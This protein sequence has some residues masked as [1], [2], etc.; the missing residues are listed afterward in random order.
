MA[1]STKRRSTKK[2][3]RGS[4]TRRSAKGR[5][6]PGFWRWSVRLALS[7]LVVLAAYT[8]YLDFRITSEFEGKRWAIPARVYARPLELYNGLQLSADNLER[9]IEAL[10]YARQAGA[11]TPGSYDRRGDTFTLHSRAFEFW[12]GSEPARRIR[13]N[14]GGGEVSAL[15]QPGAA[16]DPALVRLDP[17]RIGSIYPAKRED[18]VLVQLGEVPPTLVA[19]LIAVEDHH[20]FD[21]YG[22][23]FTGIARALVANIRAGRVVQGGS[24]LTQQ[25]VKNFFLTQDRTLWRK[26]NEAVMAVLLELHYD[27]EEILE[28]YL[29]EVYLAQ[30][31]SRAIHGFGLASRFYFAKPLQQLDLAEQALLIGMVKGPSYYNPRSNPGRAKDRRDLV[32]SEMVETGVIDEDAAWRARSSGLG[33]VPRGRT[34]VTN[35]PAFMDLVK[36]HLRRDYRY[37][38]LSTEGLRIFTTFA[39]HVQQATERALSRHLE[40]WDE[41]IEGAAVM[42]NVDD[43]EVGAVVGGRDPRYDGFNRALDAHRPIGSLIKPAIYLTALS[44]PDTYGLGTVLED[45]PV[46]LE[47]RSGNRWSPR[48]YDDA[49]HG[50]VPLWE[51]LAKSYN[52]PA[53]RLGLDLGLPAVTETLVELGGEPPRRVYPSML[54]GALPQS[55]LQV[56]RIY[57]TIASGGFRVPLRAVRGVTTAEGEPLN[58]YEL[59]VERAFSPESVYLLTTAMQRVVS[60]GTAQGLARWIPDHVQA[61]GKTGTTDDTRDSWFAGF[62][63]NRLGV[64]WVGRDKNGRTGLTGSSGAMQIWGEAFGALD[65]KP[66]EPVPP[67]DIER[68]WVQSNTGQ[69]AVAGC[70]GAV[71]LPYVRGHQPADTAPCA[72][73]RGAL[74]RAAD[75]VKGLFE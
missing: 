23:S 28:A 8:A 3:S 6:L 71:E 33:V 41:G 12:D 18:R 32:L 54:L 53:V 15:S 69:L 21:H 17:A 59:A 61:A 40:R 2:G 31:G 7:G 13:L 35:Y 19:G 38:D 43:G 27:K 11:S 37:E 9:E 26:A 72:K 57:E 55:P 70:E 47:D 36:R 74:D 52:V 46:T 10:D 44:R 58:R 42:V 66:L 16:Q 65:L 67:E 29:N 1:K 64:V 68:I 75:W 22:L 24:T 62:T 48:N 34:A 25:L 14:V 39:P 73:R 63:G 56:A 30:D 49:F 4:P 60:E 45:K 5:R 51:A 50:Q 20:F